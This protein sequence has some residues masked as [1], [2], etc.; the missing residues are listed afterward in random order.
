MSYHVLESSHAAQAILDYL[1]SNPVHHVVVGS[2][3][4]DEALK[5]IFGTFSSK[6]ANEAPCDVT[7]VRYPS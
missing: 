4:A 7:V 2:P 3:P 5:R 6:I 1:R